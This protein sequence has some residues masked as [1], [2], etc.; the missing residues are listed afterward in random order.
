[1]HRLD[2][3]TLRSKEQ[4]ITSVMYLVGTLER[5]NDAK[6]AEEKDRVVHGLK[7]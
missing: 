7:K 5:W 3:L 4:S 1:M 2:V 6:Q